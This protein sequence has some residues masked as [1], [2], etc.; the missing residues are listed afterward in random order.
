[1]PRKRSSQDKSELRKRAEKTA[2]RKKSTPSDAASNELQKV[3]LE[4]KVHQAELEIQ[5]EE[6]K[7]I[8][9]ELEESRSRYADLYDLAPVGYFTFDRVGL[10]REAN[11]TGAGLLGM[12]RRFLIG[13]PFLSFLAQESAETF[14]IHRERAFRSREKEACELKLKPRHKAPF[15]VRM[16]SIVPEAAG[17]AGISLNSTVSDVNEL[18]EA[19]E[20]LLQSKNLLEEKVR[21]RT[22]QLEGSNKEMEAFTYSISHDLRSPIRAIQGFAWM[23]EQEFGNE[24]QGELLRKFRV[25]RDNAERMGR[26]TDALLDL[27]RLRQRDLHRVPVDME[28]LAVEVGDEIRQSESGNNLKIEVEKLPPAYG[29]PQLVRQVLFN[30][31]SNAVKFS[32]NRKQPLIRVGGRSGFD[33]L[34]TYRARHAVRKTPFLF[35]SALARPEQIARGLDKG[36]DDYLIKP[37]DAGLLRS[38]VRSHLRRANAFG[39]RVTRGS[40][41]Q[42]P[43]TALVRQCERSGLTGVLEVLDEGIDVSL[44][45]TAGRLDEASVS[46]QVLEQLL[47][48]QQGRFAIISVPAAAPTI[49]LPEEAP[50]ALQ[51]SPEEEELFRALPEE[52]PSAEPAE[53][54]FVLPAATAE[55]GTAG[56][57]EL[58]PPPPMVSA[59]APPSGD[60]DPGVAAPGGMLSGLQVGGKLFQVQSEVVEGTPRRIVTVAT[61]RG[62]ALVKRESECPRWQNR[63]ELRR[64]MAEQHAKVEAEVRYR[65]E[66]FIQTGRVAAERRPSLT[67]DELFQQGK[68]RAAAGDIAEALRLW[69]EAARLEPGNALLQ[70]NIELLRAK[71]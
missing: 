47:E 23:I 66:R 54:P 25:I 55:M 26:L 70:R 22:A 63:E 41:H 38:K 64:T 48:L 12:E 16:E 69:Q 32:R 17:G 2:S 39:L 42:L 49:A 57:A 36:A 31:L 52:E 15:F 27:S 65:V 60:T 9:L 28:R 61:Y 11:L 18:V 34:N 10:I 20:A 24:L 51:L 43:F 30:L 1:M 53:A 59:V 4:L 29:D 46:D 50:E 62:K 19:R 8:Q 13:K 68:E 58:P 7:R 6:M 21:E 3:I 33:F 45:F 40:L 67:P 56:V 5:N 44:S 37:L 71:L 35:V 14:R